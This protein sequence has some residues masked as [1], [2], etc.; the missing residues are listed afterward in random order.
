MFLF[1]QFSLIWTRAWTGVQRVTS[2]GF[3]WWCQTWGMLKGQVMSSVLHNVSQKQQHKS[4]QKS[5]REIST[6]GCWWK[7]CLV[8]SDGWFDGCK[9]AHLPACSNSTKYWHDELHSCK[10]CFINPCEVMWPLAFQVCFYCRRT[11]RECCYLVGIFQCRCFSQL[12]LHTFG[13]TARRRW[14]MGYIVLPWKS[15]CSRNNNTSWCN[16]SQP[17]K[18]VNLLLQSWDNYFHWI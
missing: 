9:W 8:Q 5:S 18:I 14:S 3:R 6:G 13:L 4:V 1:L 7:C 15:I 10:E 12:H 17:L 11:A 2:L 16:A